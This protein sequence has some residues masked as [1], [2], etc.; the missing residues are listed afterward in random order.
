MNC[1]FIFRDRFV[2]SPAEKNKPIITAKYK[3]KKHKHGATSRPDMYDSGTYKAIFCT[4]KQ[5]QGGLM[6][7][8]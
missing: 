8:F 2:C 5:P 1:G 3:Y 4:K 7:T 6:V